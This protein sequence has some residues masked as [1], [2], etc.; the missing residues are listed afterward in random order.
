MIYPN[1]K[2]N[3]RL[4]PAALGSLLL[5]CISQVSSLS[6][7]QATTE[8][9]VPAAA[10]SAEPNLSTGPDGTIVLSWL[11]PSADSTLLKFSVLGEQGWSDAQTVAEGTNWFVN[12]AD[13]PSVVPISRSLWAAHWLSKKPGGT[14]S[15]DVSM[16]ISNDA[17]ASWS[18]AFTPHRDNT[19]TEH[20]FVSLFP[21]QDGVGAIWLD[22]RNTKAAGD[23]HAHGDTGGMTLRSAL[24][25]SDG[26]ISNESEM[27]ALVCDCCQTSVAL[28]IAG[29]VAVYRNR[30]EEEIRDIYISRNIAGEWQA[31]QPIHDDGWKISG[32]PVNGPAIAASADT[33]VV[34]WFTMADNIPRV[35]FARSEDGGKTFSPASDMAEN[36]PSGRV[37]VTLL[38]NGNAAVSWLD[39]TTAGKGGMK[40]R[41][42]QPDGTFGPARAVAGM[43]LSRP[44]G[45]P[46]LLADGENLIAAWTDSLG[47][48]TQVRS[49]RL[50]DLDINN[51]PAD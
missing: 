50:T 44:A 29:P 31:G 8:L 30:T 4:I 34:A 25:G 1:S 39:E 20:G 51:L 35:R 11:E 13:F 14:Y 37:D 15:Y 10:G 3:S 40:I 33:V 16:A 7:D 23:E 6:A 42:V 5:I 26:S 27:D 49:A 32:C 12:W 48:T 43:G 36:S 2:T 18:A 22:G 46:Q 9:S 41:I 19:A 24:I 47:K 21:W 28:A 38:D 45:F 17:G